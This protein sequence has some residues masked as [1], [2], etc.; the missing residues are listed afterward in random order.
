MAI[1]WHRATAAIIDTQAIV[2]NITKEKERLPEDTEIFAVVKANGYG[3]GAIQTALAAKEGGAS[4]FCVALLD[5]AIELREAGIVEPILILSVVE[6]EYVPLLLQYDLSVTVATVAW[7][8]EAATFIEAVPLKVHVK[9]DTG[10]GR[11]GFRDFPELDEAIKLLNQPEFVW[12][13]IF[14]HFSTADMADQEYYDK[15]AQRFKT[16][17]DHLEKRP[18]YVHSSNSAASFWHQPVG[19]VIRYGVAMYG[20][21]PS[22]TVLTDP[23]QLEPALSL[24]S[25]L[26]QVKEL[27]AGEGIGYGETYITEEPQW[28]GTVP[29][30]YADG[31]LRKMQGYDVLV[32]GERCPIV[33]RV[34]MDQ[35]MI[36]LPRQVP[37]G[38]KVTLIGRDQGAE[39][40]LQEVA[41]RLETIHYEVACTIS[42]R[43]PRIYK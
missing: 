3:H 39:I 7:L 23:I 33:G 8:K 26:I 34:C 12:E 16:V 15:Q 42:H 22:G 19:N 28:I 38:T 20:L 11:I 6:P 36:R 30:G 25:N 41:D 1:G 4:G 40:T 37:I 18:R 17:L 9:I 10:M 35:C 24:V 13:G 32:D 21:N 43:V 5:E 29:I 2:A 14:T 27:P 31:W